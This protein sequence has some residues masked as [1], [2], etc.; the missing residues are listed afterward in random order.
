MDKEMVKELIQDDLNKVN[1]EKE[2]KLLLDPSYKGKLEAGYAEL[3]QKLGGV[4]ASE[5]AAKAMLTS[6]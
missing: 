4:G 3:Q 2:L 6:L 1:L 5:H